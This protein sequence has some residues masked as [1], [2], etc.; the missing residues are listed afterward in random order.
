M[1]KSSATYLAPHDPGHPEST[2][3]QGSC[4]TIAEVKNFTAF[5]TAPKAIRKLLSLVRP[6]RVCGT[7][8]QPT[9][10]T[11]PMGTEIVVVS[12]PRARNQQDSPSMVPVQCIVCFSPLDWRYRCTS[13]SSAVID[14]LPVP[15]CILE[16]APFSSSR[17]GMTGTGR[18]RIRGAR[19]G[20]R[21][22]LA[23][24]DGGVESKL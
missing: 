19:T 16:S 11:D 3:E 4:A 15:I 20:T 8:C 21:A 6:T 24:H 17:Q 10:M 5:L 2:V 9:V 18:P 14:G 22:K 1:A 13:A 23:Q 12:I 7:V